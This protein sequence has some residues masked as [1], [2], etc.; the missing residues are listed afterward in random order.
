MFK[1]IELDINENLTLLYES[2][3]LN[4]I[5]V[6]ITERNNLQCVWV[7]DQALVPKIAEACRR[8]C[9][10]AEVRGQIAAEVGAYKA[11]SRN[12]DKS[13]IGNTLL[14]STARFPLVWSLIVLLFLVG[15]WTG[16]GSFVSQDDFY[17]V[18]PAL[19]GAATLAD[20]VTVLML[21]LQD[22]Q[23][24]RLWTPALI[25]LGF[26]HLLGNVLGLFIF[27]RAVE[28]HYGRLWMGLLII[29]S[30][31]ISNLA[32][33]LFHGA[34][35]A[36]FSGVVYALVGVHAAGLVIDRGNPLWGP[37]AFVVL[38]LVGL[39]LGITNA[40]ALFDVYMADTAHFFGF[41]CGVLWQS[42]SVMNRE[43]SRH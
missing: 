25:H 42:C 9:S 36:G 43:N 31:L 28:V 37:K 2:F 22:G 11:S 35:F 20:R 18:P 26:L 27:G 39:V 19:Y 34:G 6:K 4:G 3:R 32:Q 24:W 30:A 41:I 40:Y 13:G 1:A 14:I 16:V 29:G 17:I 12:S 7:D 38:A 15:A 33:Y 8:Y 23:F 5:Q 21:V 10:N